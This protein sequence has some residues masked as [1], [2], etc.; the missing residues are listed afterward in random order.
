MSTDEF[1][2]IQEEFIRAV[3]EISY[4]QPELSLEIE[5]RI[6]NDPAFFYATGRTAEKF[7]AQV[8]ERR[9]VKGITTNIFIHGEGATQVGKSIAALIIAFAEDDNFTLERLYFDF[10]ELEN[11]LDKTKHNVRYIVD[12]VRR[13]FGTGSKAEVV[14]IENF[15]ETNAKTGTSLTICKPEFF[16]LPS[17]H[18]RIEM[19]GFCDGYSLGILYGRKGKPIAWLRFAIPDELLEIIRK[20]QEMKYAYMEK[21]RLKAGGVGGYVSGKIERIILDIQEQGL[22]F[23]SPKKLRRFIVLN[24]DHWTQKVQE[25]ANAELQEIL[26]PE[27][28]AVEMESVTVIEGQKFREF[29]LDYLPPSTIRSIVQLY[30]K[31]G[32]PRQDEVAK[33]LHLDSAARVSEQ[34]TRFTEKQL[35]DLYEI[36][37]NKGGSPAKEG[38]VD[39]WEDD[40]PTNL[41]ATYSSRKKLRIP[42]EKMQPEINS[43]LEHKKKVRIRAYNLFFD[44]EVKKDFDPKEVNK[45]GVAVVN[46]G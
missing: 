15:L 16:E 45:R 31:K 1:I 25:A 20:Y 38:K 26:F 14:G 22:E 46:F 44:K 24:Y 41:K 9:K 34:I 11:A 28:E 8:L 23:E 33:E 18:Y 27:A 32:V 21:I 43:A 17:I 13:R 5:S 2:N 6:R 7:L 37:Y 36:W 19:L 12:D 30:H 39:A 40:K 3:E 29:L 10:T 35:G 4:L 42:V